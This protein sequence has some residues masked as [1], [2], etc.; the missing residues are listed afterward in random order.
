MRREKEK[1]KGKGKDQG[2][3]NGERRWGRERKGKGVVIPKLRRLI[4]F[5]P[6]SVQMGSNETGFIYKSNLTY[7]RF[8][9]VFNKLQTISGTVIA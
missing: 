8:T 1:R 3:G 2:K 7:L 4:I 9:L 5:L 6:L